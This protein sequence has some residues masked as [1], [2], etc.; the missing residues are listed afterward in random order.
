MERTMDVA[1]LILKSRADLRG[2]NGRRF[3]TAA[4]GSKAPAAGSCHY[5]S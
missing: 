1:D 2:E 4:Q 3:L 5:E